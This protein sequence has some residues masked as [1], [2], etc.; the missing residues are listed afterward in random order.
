[1]VALDESAGGSPAPEVHWYQDT[2]GIPGTIDRPRPSDFGVSAEDVER[3]PAPFVTRHRFRIFLALYAVIWLIAF[4]VIWL[5][6]S[7]VAAAAAF[8]AIGVGA[9]SVILVPILL[10]LVCACEKAETKWLCRTF[11][12]LEACLA[13]REAMAAF[14]RLGEPPPAPRKDLAWWRDL[15]LATLRS[16]VERDLAAR[17]LDVDPV[18]DRD[19]AGYDFTFRDDGS[20]VLVRCEAG[21]SEVGIGVGRELTACLDETGAARAV[22]V[23]PAGAS[24]DLRSYVVDRPIEIV[25]PATI[26]ADPPAEL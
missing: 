11:P 6:S 22:L 21:R 19:A 4:S 18:S 5:L 14:R 24:S 26:L 12:A 8:A 1:M 20:T 15:S 9:V 7:S 25:D 13:Y 10:C 23:A 2:M 17:G 3:A 16:Q